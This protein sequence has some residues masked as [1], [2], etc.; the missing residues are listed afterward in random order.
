MLE[1]V[2]GRPGEGSLKVR[3]VIEPELG[4][5]RSVGWEPWRRPP[6]ELPRDE[7][8]S[9][10]CSIR[11]VWT[12]PTDVGGGVWLRSA[13]AAA[14]EERLGLASLLAMKA[15]EAAVWADAEGVVFKG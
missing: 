15:F 11:F 5:R 3:D 1:P 10:R 4:V 12:L 8:D 2:C 7:F 6:D 9:C 13:A 14:A